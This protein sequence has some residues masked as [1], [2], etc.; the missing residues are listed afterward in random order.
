[1]EPKI[2]TKI[3]KKSGLKKYAGVW[4][5]V[6]ALIKPRRWLLALGFLLMVINRVAMLV[7]PYMSKYLIDDVVR[8]REVQILL[9]IILVVLGATAVQG[10]T[11]FSLTQL[12]SK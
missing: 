10:V 7:T 12:L 8:K 3:E 2:V 1:M 4:P 6:W 5:Q 11:S 9:P